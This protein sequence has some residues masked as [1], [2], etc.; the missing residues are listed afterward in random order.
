MK[1]TGLLLTTLFLATLVLG[2][3]SN[4][5]EG[6]GRDLSGAGEWLQDTF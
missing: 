1:K 5:F 4:T 6:A 2:G 3:C